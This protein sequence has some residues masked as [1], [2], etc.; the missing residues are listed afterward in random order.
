MKREDVKSV[1]LNITD[2]QLQRIMDMHSD[3]I[4]THKQSITTLTAERDAARQQLADANE[5]LE[6]YDPA[7][8][9][10]ATD[11]RRH[12]APQLGPLKRQ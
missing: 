11:A 4:G 10:K 1:I 5:K 8:K 2:E 7:W 12:A 9:Q 3:D 6:G